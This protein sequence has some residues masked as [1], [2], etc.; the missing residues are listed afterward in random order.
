MP[1]HMR[2]ATYARG[3]AALLAALTLALACLLAACGGKEESSGSASDPAAVAPADTAVYAEVRLRLDDDAADGVATA[4]RRVTLIGDPIGELRRSLEDEVSSEGDWSFARDIEPWLGDRAGVFVLQA[5][6]DPELDDPDVGVVLTVDDEDAAADAMARLAEDDEDRP[7]RGTYEGTDYLADETDDTWVGIV[8]GY[9][10]LGTEA[11]F[12]AAVDAARGDDLG[13]S[14]RYDEALDAVPD[15][16]LAFAYVDTEAFLPAITATADLDDPFVRR[17]LDQLRDAGAATLALTANADE[18][19]LEISGDDEALGVSENGGGEVSI[20]DL[21]GD[22]WAALATPPLGPAIRQAVEQAGEYDEAARQLQAAAGLDLDRDVLGWLGGVAAFVRGTA[23]LELGGGIVIGSAD[24]AASRRLVTRIER[25]VGAFGVSP[26]PVGGGTGFEV[27]VPDLPQ[28]IAVIAQGDKVAIGLGAPSA[29]DALDPGESFA[30]SGDGK[31]VLD[32]LGEGFQ[33][34]FALVL[35][36]MLQLVRAVGADSDPDVREALPYLSAYRSIAAG[37][38]RADGKATV[39]I[40]AGLQ[41][42][43]P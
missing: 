41:D 14:D 37:T 39:R 17:S 38:K 20:D 22:A 11:G 4:L 8:D 15:D 10:V 43:T 28:P 5:P 32:T 30:G 33:P 34:S 35:G 9:F 23:P 31:A 29:R 7:T 27:A 6:G 3:R 21:P 16:A 1:Q 24:A 26:R 19:A 25:M 2:R 36:P 13:A 18:V 40:V 12:R 42:P